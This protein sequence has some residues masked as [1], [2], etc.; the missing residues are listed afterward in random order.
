MIQSMDKELIGEVFTRYDVDLVEEYPKL[1]S[2]DKLSLIASVTL[3]LV[4]F[5]I[6]I[7]E[8]IT[9]C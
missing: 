8:T 5:D 9:S 7:L 3:A 2:I 4:N 1:T 6:M